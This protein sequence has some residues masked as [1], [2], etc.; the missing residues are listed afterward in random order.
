[1]SYRRITV[2]VEDGIVIVD[3]T[4]YPVDCSI[5]PAGV[6]AIQWADGAGWMEFEGAPNEHF[7]DARYNAVLAPFVALWE[8][9]RDRPV[10]TPPEATEA[11]RPSEPLYLDAIDYGQADRLFRADKVEKLRDVVLEILG[12]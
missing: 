3:G 4:S 7:T 6:R 2:V 1:M 11:P 9:E 8:A 12:L 10:E 5:S